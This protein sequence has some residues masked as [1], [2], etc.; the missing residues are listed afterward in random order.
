MGDLKARLRAEKLGQHLRRALGEPVEVEVVSSYADL[1]RRLRDGDVDVAWAPPMLAAEARPR[2][3]LLLKAIRSGR[4]VFR[5]ALVGRSEDALALDK[6]EGLRAAWVAP[7]AM[8]GYLL[9]TRYLR[10]K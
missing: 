5:A 6:L 9:P 3:K 7:L 1:E 2:A 10:E 4:D 8:A